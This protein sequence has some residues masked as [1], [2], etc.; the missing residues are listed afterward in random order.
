M[1]NPRDQA[2]VEKKERI[3]KNVKQQKQNQDRSNQSAK[4]KEIHQQKAVRKSELELAIKNTKSSTASLGRFDKSLSNETAPKNKHLK[5]KFDSNTS[6]EVQERTSKI[7]KGI[8]SKTSDGGEVI[9][10]KLL[11]KVDGVATPEATSPKRF[12]EPSDNL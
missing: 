7:V 4:T 10:S 8:M 11:K 9:G 5:R 2:R 6:S 1:E 12:K 3:A